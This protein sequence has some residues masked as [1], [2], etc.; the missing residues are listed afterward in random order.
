MISDK[1][2]C[3]FI[4]I[5]RTG[6]TSIGRALLG[7]GRND[8]LKLDSNHGPKHIVAKDA[9]K[10][11]GNKRWNSYFKFSIV[12]NPWDLVVSNYF[13]P[14]FHKKGEGVG[15]KEWLLRWENNSEWKNNTIRS[16]SI[17]QLNAISINNKIVM[18]YIIRYETL[19]EQWKD[20]ANILSAK[21]VLE[22][23][24]KYRVEKYSYLKE[25]KN[26]PFYYD[27]ESID[28]VARKY[29]KDIEYFGYKFGD[30]IIEK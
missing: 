2:K 13:F 26:Y 7:V 17:P 6:G 5:E 4:H 24:W 27:Q 21:P 30:N 12:R 25:R 20:V 19:D 28:I 22:N 29:K 16:N 23:D 3:I 1:Y 14:W 15:F 9:K 11:I 18:D 8:K 10:M